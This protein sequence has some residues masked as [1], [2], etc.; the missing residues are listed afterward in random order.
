MPPLRPAVG[1]TRWGRVW[2][3][4]VLAFVVGA[5]LPLAAW[6]AWRSSGAPKPAPD[7]TAVQAPAPQP[8]AATPSQSLSV[9]ERFP[10][11]AASAQPEHP[12][13]RPS[14]ADMLEA[15]LPAVVTLHPAGFL[16]ANPDEAASSVSMRSGSGVVVSD[17]GYIL[18]CLHVISDESGAL[19]SYIE[20]GLSDGRRMPATLIGSDSRTDLALLKV[21][22]ENVP[23]LR[24]ANSDELRV[25]DQVYAIGNPLDVGLT[26]TS[27]IVSAKSRSRLGLLGSRGV[28][29]FIQTDVAIHP[30]NSGGALVDADGSLC[31]ITTASINARGGGASRLG[32]AIPANLARQVLVSL[33]QTG[34][35]QRGYLDIGTMIPVQVSRGGMQVPGLRIMS[36]SPSAP[37]ALAVGDIILGLGGR[38][39]AT[40]SD[41]RAAA[42]GM[43]PGAEVSMQILRDGTEFSTAI[44]VG[45]DPEPSAADASRRTTVP[46]LPGVAVETL[47][48][49]GRRF[50]NLSARVHGVLVARVA[51][52]CP[53]AATLKDGMVILEANK[54]TVSKPADLDAAL[55]KGVNRILVHERGATA[56]IT[57][58]LR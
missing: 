50:Y 31:G 38:T 28:E 58:V 32:F 13:A 33:L 7:A 43:S 3:F 24:M 11:S 36:I 20:A 41:L 22:V 25:G 2:L 47:E 9:R 39:V 52:D 12:V 42:A 26:V 18:T 29:D 35:V 48:D 44:T 51:S 45:S 37:V 14:P 17:D 57:L 21:D 53:H 19:A 49:D 16:S 40:P 5:G 55:V 8:P 15:T 30:G 34:A 10:A 4:A 23:F 1:E 27:G 46:L 6:L 54:H 56:Y